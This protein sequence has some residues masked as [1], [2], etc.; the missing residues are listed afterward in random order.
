[1]TEQRAA[2]EAPPEAI[3][4]AATDVPKR[5]IVTMDE[6]GKKLP[7]GIPTAEGRLN[8]NFTTRPWK[9]KDERALGKLKKPSMTLGRYVGTVIAHMCDSIGDTN[10]SAIKKPEERLVHIQRMFMGDV[11]YVYCWLRHESMGD[12]IKL[13]FTCPTCAKKLPY[14]GDLMTTQVAVVDDLEALRWKYELQDPVEIRGKQVEKLQMSSPRWTAV[15]TASGSRDEANAKVTAI[16]SSIIAFNDEQDAVALGEAELD[17]L[18]KRDLEALS[19]AIDDRFMGPNMALEGKCTPE[20]CP[21][22]GGYD[23][24]VPIDWSYDNFFSNSSK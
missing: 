6:W 2:F 23:F 22:G 13:N 5:R 12:R 10:L 14:V 8:K 24:R 15:D 20:M 17:E 4:D 9:T 16:R 1:M 11:F 21:M 19:A 3:T 18:S 7:I